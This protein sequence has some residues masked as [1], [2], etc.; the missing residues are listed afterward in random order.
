MQFLA[1]TDPQTA[2]RDV[3]TVRMAQL[4]NLDPELQGIPD[5][6]VAATPGSTPPSIPASS[7]GSDSASNAVAIA[8]ASS[9]SRY[10]IVQKYGL[11]IIGLVGGN[12][13]VLLVLLVVNIVSCVKRRASSGS[14]RGAKY[15]QVRF[16]EAEPLEA[17]E[18]Q[19]QSRYS[20]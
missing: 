13:L 6:F 8:D 5:G 16:K 11:I 15:A 10:S 18:F 3:Q 12:L 14:P 20:D 17:E 4:A 19:E 9:G 2:I 7:A 1:Q